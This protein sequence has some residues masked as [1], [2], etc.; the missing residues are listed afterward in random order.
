MLAVLVSLGTWQVHRLHWKEGVLAQ[1]A[2]SERAAPTPLARDPAPYSKVSA[3]GR[4]RFDRIARFGAEVRDTSLGPT[5]GFYQVVPLDRGDGTTILVNRGWAP[6]KRQAALDEPVGL[7]TVTGYV[8]PGDKPSWFSAAD[9]VPGR[10]FFTLD[11]PVIAAA[12]GVA[13]PLPF[14]LVALGPSAPGVFPAPAQHLPE[15]PN[16]HLTY[17]VTW[18][19]LAAAL[20]VIF[21]VWMRKALRS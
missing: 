1:I 14:A 19:G 4:F 9:D 12:L 18:Y 8:R 13:N 5:L 20:L 10:Q 15:P 6:Q 11:P 16:N 17:A 2:E 21:A 7:V 3:S